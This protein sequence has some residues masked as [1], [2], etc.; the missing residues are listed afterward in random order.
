MLIQEYRGRRKLYH[1]DLYR[2]EGAALDELGLEELP[3]G[4]GVLV[5][6]WADR[7]PRPI[8]GA[9]RVKLEDK[10]E[11]VREIAIETD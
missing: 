6:E 2:L 10:G 1:V 8:A 5:V 7:L 3:G 9:M 4:D 11:N